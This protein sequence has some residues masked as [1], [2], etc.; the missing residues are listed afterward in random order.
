MIESRFRPPSDI[1]ANQKLNQMDNASPS[2]FPLGPTYPDEGGILFHYIGIPFP[3]KGFAYGEAVGS[4]QVPKKIVTMLAHVAR[5]CPPVALVAAIF[6]L[7]VADIVT[8][9]CYAPLKPYELEDKRYCKAA[10]ATYEALMVVAASKKNARWR[11]VY[12]RIARIARALIE[13]DDSYRY[14]YQDIF[15]DLLIKEFFYEN[16]AAEMRFFY[17]VSMKRENSSD[18]RFKIFQKALSTLLLFPSVRK[19]AILFVK[20]LDQEMVKLDEGDEYYCFAR[21]G[22]DI[23]GWKREDR[24]AL[25]LEIDKKYQAEHA[26]E[27]QAQIEKWNQK[28]VAEVMKDNVVEKGGFPLFLF[29]M[30][31][32][33]DESRVGMLAS[34]AA[35]ENEGLWEDCRRLLKR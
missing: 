18:S 27:I 21:P 32:E 28:T 8:T 10:R 3:K 9:A 30:R 1:F 29:Y 19:D 24:K 2:S 17:D 15:G 7:T 6:P 26:E 20:N 35:K 12:E 11:A 33:G 23:H 22:Y 16:P 13:W 31:K 14:R 25:R 4:L 34:N 5:R